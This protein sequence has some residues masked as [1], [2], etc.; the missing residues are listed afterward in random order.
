[1][2]LYYSYPICHQTSLEDQIF[3]AP[4]CFHHVQIVGSVRTCQQQTDCVSGV[5]SGEACPRQVWKLKH[6]FVLHMYLMKDDHKHF[7]Y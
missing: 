2:G 7:M 3:E 5:F 1:M 6:L 4:P